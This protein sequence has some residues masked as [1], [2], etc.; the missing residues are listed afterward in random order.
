MTV[1]AIQTSRGQNVGVPGKNT[2]L[3]NGRPLFQYALEAAITA[4]SVDAVI[5]A[6]DIPEVLAF[7]RSAGIG[8]LC[9]EPNIT[10]GNHYGA[11]LT[12]TREACRLY[13]DVQAVVVLLG[14]AL[15]ASA[16]SLDA[17]VSRLLQRPEADSVVS[18]SP[19]PM[20][21]P[22][23]AFSSDGARL[24]TTVPAG[25]LKLESASNDRYALGTPWFFNGS[26]WVIRPVSILRNDGLPPFPW[27]GHHLLPF[28]Q[29]PLMELDE[30]WQIPIIGHFRAG[31]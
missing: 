31:A 19:F 18:V 16:S 23:R 14:N 20:F 10:D 22:L 25:V 1:V 4:S 30:E 29:A 26:F 21:N 28:E 13:Q 27:L 7:A 5:A 6:T 12:G 3:V 2:M 11:I 15:G 24:T 8:T 17:A 9:L